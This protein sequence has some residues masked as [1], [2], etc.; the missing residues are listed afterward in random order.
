VSQLMGHIVR[1]I[2]RPP[3]RD[4]EGND[5][6]RVRIL[7]GQEVGDDSFEVGGF[8]IGLWPDVAQSAQIV[9]H[10]VDVTIIATR[11]D[12]GCPVGPTH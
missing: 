12:R 7:A 9:F 1:C 5:A 11:H 6:Q 10:H 8:G 4:I 3:L 2:P